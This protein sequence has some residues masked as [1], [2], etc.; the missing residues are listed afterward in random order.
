MKPTLDRVLIRGEELP[1]KTKT[2]IYLPGEEWKTLPP[3]GEVLAVGPDVKSV[4]KGDRVVF[5]RFGAVRLNDKNE[6]LCTEKQIFGV[7]DEEVKE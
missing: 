1:R 5:D 4:K 3:Y 2:G 7:V 6:V